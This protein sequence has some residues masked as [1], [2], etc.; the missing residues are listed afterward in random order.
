MQKKYFFW[1]IALVGSLFL[2]LIPTSYDRIIREGTD[3]YGAHH[4]L[5]GSREKTVSAVAGSPIEQIGL[6]IVN[7]RH[8]PALA[9]VTITVSPEGGASFSQ[10]RELS[11]SIDDDFIWFDVESGS[12]AKGQRFVVRVSAPRA[13]IDEPVGLR[14][15]IQDRQLALA[16]RER[17]PAWEQMIRWSDAHPKRAATS[18]FVIVGALSVATALLVLDAISRTY[19]RSTFVIALLLLTALIL[20]TRIP[21]SNALESAFGGD[22][23]NYILKGNAWIGGEDPFAAD[24]R[25]APLYPF[26]TMPGLLPGLDPIL[27]AR[28]ISIVSTIGTV[29]IV[30]LVLRAMNVSMPIAV[31]SGALLAVNRDYQFESVQGLSNPLYTFFIISAVYAFVSKKIYLVSV[32]A[33]LAAITRFEGALVA[34]I[35]VPAS[36]IMH[37]VRIARILR[38]IVPMVVIGGLPLILFPFTRELGIRSVDDLRSDEGLYIGYTWDYLAPSMKA[39]RIIFGRLWLLTEHVGNPFISFGLGACVGLVGVLFFKKYARP[40]AALALIPA[41]VAVAMLAG[42][43][44]EF[45]NQQKFFIAMFSLLAGGGLGAAL[46]SRPKISIPIACM[47]LLQ[48]A[49]VTAILPKNRYYLQ[50]IPFIAM[51]FGAAFWYMGGAGKFRR[52]PHAVAVFVFAIFVVFAYNDAKSALSG[53]ISDYNE[54]S[55]G[56]TVL[57]LSGREAKKL[58]GIIAAAQS[59]DLILRAYVPRERL[60]FFPDSVRGVGVQFAL[61]R[62]YHAMYLIDRTEDPYFTKLIDEYREYFEQVAVFKTKWGND[63]ATL[64]RIKPE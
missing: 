10:T 11:A 5:Y 60:V 4:A 20:A 44:L 45:E 36:W 57:M 48:V 28:G 64:Y 54:K 52:L 1:I 49:V 12:I 55:A 29:L 38:F 25:K 37:R 21:I 53:Q 47:A 35:L 30:V 42:L 43:L 46:V 23:F 7:L 8:A 16:V 2:A 31:L 34:A 14:F 56:Q 50:V 18:I 17:I 24:P 13:T 3:E 33:A 63:T 26:L 9:P 59:S 58:S 19:P 40:R 27:W 41:L 39:L 32:S 6:V 61:L 22:A 15:S 62:Q 51:S